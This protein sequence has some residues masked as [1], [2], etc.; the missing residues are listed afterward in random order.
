MER[1]SYA[2]RVEMAHAVLA[3]VHERLETGGFGDRTAALLT[4]AE[5]HPA[6]LAEVLASALTVAS[7]ASTD[8][9]GPDVLRDCAATADEAHPGAGELMLAVAEADA[10]DAAF[11]S[12]L[13]RSQAG[14]VRTLDDLARAGIVA[15]AMVSR[16]FARA[17]TDEVVAWWLG[18]DPALEGEDPAGEQRWEPLASALLRAVTEQSGPHGHVPT[19]AALLTA[20]RDLLVTSK[21]EA[22]LQVVQDALFTTVQNEQIDPDD[23]GDVTRRL[24]DAFPRAGELWMAVEEDVALVRGWYDEL[25]E[26]CSPAPIEV[27]RRMPALARWLGDLGQEDGIAE[28]VAAAIAVFCVGPVESTLDD[29]PDGELLELWATGDGATEIVPRPRRWP[30]APSRN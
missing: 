6:V 26:R 24:D 5:H 12:W 10:A 17:T 20:A 13:T 19:P 25:V 14:S 30:P 23:L 29:L 9:Y 1:A 11:T 28:Y 18:A 4:A 21:P 15:L 8:A 22:L 2:Q 3:A 27:A 16:Q 7:S